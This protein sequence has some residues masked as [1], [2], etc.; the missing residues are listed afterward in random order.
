MAVTITL[1]DITKEQFGELS[2]HARKQGHSLHAWLAKEY[3]VKLD[4]D[5]FIWL[6]PDEETALEFAFKWIFICKR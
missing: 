2:M 3:N 6:F 1:K 4:K 5:C